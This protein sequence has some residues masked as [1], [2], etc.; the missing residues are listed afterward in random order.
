MIRLPLLALTDLSGYLWLAALVALNILGSAFCS[1]SEAALLASSEA[2]IRVR[3]REGKRG[4]SRL[5]AIR[6]EPGDTLAAIVFLNNVFAIAGTAFITAQATHVI[7]SGWGMAGFIALQTVLIIAFGEIVP[8]ILGEAMPEPIASFLS[9][10]LVAVRRAMRPLVVVVQALIYWA[11]PRYRVTPGQETEIR[12]LA[13]LGHEGGH[14]DPDEAELIHRVFRLDDIT[15]EDVMTPRALIQGFACERTLEEERDRLIGAH[16]SQF[17]VYEG[18]LD[19]VV[20]TLWLRDA[21]AA[22]ASGQGT[23][24]IAEVMR[25]PLFVPVSRT[26][27]DVLRDMQAKHRRMMVVIDEYGATLGI[28]TMDDLVE[29]LVGEAIDETDVSAGLVKRISKTAALVHGLTRV[30]DVARFLKADV[31]FEDPDDETNTVTGLLQDRLGR[32]PE[33]GDI[34]TVP[35]ALMGLT[36]E[37]READARMAVRVLAR[38]RTRPRRAADGEEGGEATSSGPVSDSDSES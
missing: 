27:D 1:L 25:T 9:P 33:R 2:R 37:V 26:V 6:R 7:F 16:F 4:A 38:N 36:L 13:R 23:R 12:E 35:G 3:A 30:L 29:E 22:L 5:L 32:I 20:G 15:A 24:T 10:A 34:L 11:R 19:K 21:L 8:K 31:E 18:D 17:P 14:L 28:I